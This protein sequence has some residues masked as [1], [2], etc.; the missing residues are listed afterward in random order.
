M[1]VTAL[2]ILLLG[3]AS[4]TLITMIAVARIEREHPPA[5]RFVDVPGARLHVVELG[6]P[7]AA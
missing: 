3:A 1:I 5:G 6:P 2:V 7:R 4:A